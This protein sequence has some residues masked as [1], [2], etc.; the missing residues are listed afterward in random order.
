MFGSVFGVHADLKDNNSALFDSLGRVL[1]H[2]QEILWWGAFTV[3]Y[4]HIRLMS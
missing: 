1:S 2:I 3:S 4:P